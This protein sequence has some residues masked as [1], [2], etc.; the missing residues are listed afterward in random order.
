[1]MKQ[2]FED[3]KFPISCRDLAAH[4]FESTS[5]AAAVKQLGRWVRADP[6]LE[7]DLRAAGWRPGQKRFTRMQA[8]VLCKYFS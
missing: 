3:L 5:P 7:A 8:A 1:M 2:K 4:F 6:Q